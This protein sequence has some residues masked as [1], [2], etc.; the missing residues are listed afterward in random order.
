MLAEKLL[1]K[2][3]Y[4]HKWKDLRKD[5]IDVL[6]FDK[7]IDEFCIMMLKDFDKVEFK[8]ISEENSSELL[9]EKRKS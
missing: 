2:L 5:G 9:K 6:L 7:K 8:N 1:K 3:S 4:Y